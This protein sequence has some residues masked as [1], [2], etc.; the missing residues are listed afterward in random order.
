M[1]NS[2]KRGEVCLVFRDFYDK[3]QTWSGIYRTVRK[4]VM[5]KK[6]LTQTSLLRQDLVS[7]SRFSNCSVHP[8]QHF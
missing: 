1:D 8:T 6:V 4:S 5:A 2:G 7:H 3:K